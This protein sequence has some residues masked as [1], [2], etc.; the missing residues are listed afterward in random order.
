MHHE[1]FWCGDAFYFARR[2]WRAFFTVVHDLV[3][4]EF[5]HGANT[6]MFKALLQ[7]DSRA[8]GQILLA[9]TS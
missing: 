9:E 1:Q 5:R 6:G 3:A 8:E 4:C 2:G 7:A